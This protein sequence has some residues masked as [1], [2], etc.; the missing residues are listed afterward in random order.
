[1]PRKDRLCP[2]QLALSCNAWR[3]SSELAVKTAKHASGIG[4]ATHSSLPDY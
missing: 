3:E 2:R 4:Q 1:M